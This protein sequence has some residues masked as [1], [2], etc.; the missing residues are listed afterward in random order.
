MGELMLCLAIRIQNEN[1]AKSH[2]QQSVYQHN[3]SSPLI[4]P[5][6]IKFLL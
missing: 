5:T 1:M 6:N 3:L 2:S 4:A